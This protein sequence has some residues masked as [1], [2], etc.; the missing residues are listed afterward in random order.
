[1]IV[2]IPLAFYIDH[3]ERALPCP[4]AV[5]V[6]RSHA[7]IDTTDPAFPELVSDARFYAGSDDGSPGFAGTD[8]D[9]ATRAA[10]AL[11]KA[12]RPDVPTGRRCMV[13]SRQHGVT[14]HVAEIAGRMTS[15]PA[16]VGCFRRWRKGVR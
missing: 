7:W 6:T 10:R 2:R 1:M 9:W 3:D 4:E 14:F 13:C 8:C 11:L 12:L 15:V 16:H 5:K